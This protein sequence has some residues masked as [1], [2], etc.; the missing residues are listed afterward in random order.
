MRQECSE[1]RPDR[2]ELRQRPPAV[3][4]DRPELR[5]HRPDPCYAP[6]KLRHGRPE[7]RHDPPEVRYG[8]PEVR[9]DRPEP[10]YAPPEPCYG[11]PAGCYRCRMPSAPFRSALFIASLTV[12][13]EPRGWRHPSVGN[14]YDGVYPSESRPSSSS[15]QASAFAKLARCR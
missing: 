6:P 1:V 8:P 14:F 4:H 9:H 2:R 5:H 13:E 3:R 11:P 12:R 10:C 15:I 7:L